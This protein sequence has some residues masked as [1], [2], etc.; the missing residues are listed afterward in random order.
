MKIHISPLTL[1][2]GLLVGLSSTAS[3][4]TTWSGT[5]T[6]WLGNATWSAGV[7]NS[8]TAAILTGNGTLNVDTAATAASLNLNNASGTL[9][10]S[11]S[12]GNSLAVSGA[13]TDGGAGTANISLNNTNS[14]NATTVL[15]ATSITANQL[16]LTVPVSTNTTYFTYGND[17]TLATQ[18]NLGAGGNNGNNNY[19][20]TQTGGTLSITSNAYGLSIGQGA[21]SSGGNGTNIFNL[22]GGTIAAARIGV[23]NGDG[24][25][26]GTN[27]YAMDGTLN[28]N[29]GTIRNLNT[30][31]GL[32]IT[33]GYANAGSTANTMQWDTSKPLNMVLANTGTHEFQANTASIVVAP[34]AQ[35][36]G[37]GGFTKT[38]NGTMAFTGGGPVAVN[39]WSG[40][41]TVSAGTVASDY[42]LIAG[43]AATGGTDTLSGAY[44]ATSRLILDGGNFTL[45]GRG[46]AAGSSAN[47]TAHTATSTT[48]TLAST[49][50]LVIGQAVS[51]TNVPTGT[52]I[53]QILNGTQI[54]L[55][56]FS[57]GNNSLSGNTL[58]FGAASFANTQTINNVTLN[59]TTSTV[60]VNPGAGTSTTLLSFGN[61]TGSGGLAKAGTGTLQLTGTLD[62]TGATAV[63]AGT[64]EFAPTSG[65]STLTGNVTGSAAI[66]KS[67]AGTT[68]IAN[69]GGASLNSFSGSVRVDAG[70]LRLGQSANSGR[71]LGSAASLTINNGGT[72]EYL[73]DGINASAAVTVNAGG[74]LTAG[75]GG[76]HSVFSN[77]T[78]NGGTFRTG[79]GLSTAFQSAALNGNVTVTGTTAST[80]ST[81]GGN[82]SSLQLASN[83]S[84]VTRNI[85]VA[86]VTSSSAADLTVSAVLA[87]S[88]NVGGA[89]GLAK[90][91]LGTMVLSANNTYTGNTLVSAGTLVLN[92]SLNAA[93]SV[94][95]ASGATLGGS[96]TIN[97]SASISGILAPGNSIGTLNIGSTTWNGAASALAATDW[98]FEL[99]AA[100]A[101]D[102]LNI[103]GDFV[104][105]TAAGSVFRF[106]F[107]GST[108]T[109]NFTIVD[110]S[111][112]T[113]F[114]ASDFSY[115]G[116][117]GGNTGTFAFSGSSL[118]FNVVPEPSTLALLAASLTTLMVFRRRRN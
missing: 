19:V 31:T 71:G 108:S 72:V 89:S 65:T 106:D 3:A 49:S 67:G 7:P 84:N 8:S 33:N 43:T 103:T 27:R 2:A 93:S 38:G 18:L 51:G 6:N 63:S 16:Q 1:L 83:T 25:N 21:S 91:G 14:S 82:F 95:V 59:A 115:T 47:A 105:N 28:F 62:Y 73:R 117:G 99:G 26:A 60:T 30:S 24:N 4:Q 87:D 56:H 10:L 77:L 41:T 50:G 40:N 20:Y 34:S 104:K 12:N 11:I 86:D 9:T 37:L 45:T 97:G 74:M 81:L 80:I 107:M 94:S 15:S 13:I 85:V 61:V 57:T 22:N 66:V 46:S 36:T 109:G 116:L 110:W 70:I 113:S 5:G 32:T 100:N 90:L 98:Q 76:A 54:Q 23:N 55:S 101:A 35:L 92:G 42:N 75:T 96:G 69:T 111:V 53:R 118:Q 64:L 112:S 39:S 48:V 102:L 114:L 44:S 88:S 68:V 78:L 52:Y 17:V 79:Q 58:T 29:N